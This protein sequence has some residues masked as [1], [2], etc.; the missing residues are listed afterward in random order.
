MDP[1]TRSEPSIRPVLSLSPAPIRSIQ[2][3]CLPSTQANRKEGGHEGDGIGMRS[4][5]S[6]C[7]RLLEASRMKSLDA[8]GL[9]ASDIT[10]AFPAR[11]SYRYSTNELKENVL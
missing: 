4:Y 9:S 7:E 1:E 3:E 5:A 11:F 6:E 8:G 2:F 10:V